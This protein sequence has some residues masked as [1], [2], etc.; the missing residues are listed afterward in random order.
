MDLPERLKI[1]RNSLGKSQKAMAS[2]LGI[3]TRSWQVYEEGKSKPGTDVY[4]SLV[5]LGI[6][7]N[8][9]LTGEGAMRRGE[10]GGGA[11]TGSNM[12]QGITGSVFAQSINGQ[13]TA[14]APRATNHDLDELVIL[15]ERYGNKAI[16]ERFKAD[17]LRIKETIER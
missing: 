5:K 16:Y 4:A 3:V 13:A 10:E 2:E 8:W 11:V 14:G 12:A 15:L 9:L 6:N 17:L 1:V 7:A